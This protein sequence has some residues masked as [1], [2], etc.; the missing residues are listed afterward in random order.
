MT[1]GYQGEKPAPFIAMSVRQLVQVAIVGLLVGLVVYGLTY[2]L[3]TYVY[4]TILCRGSTAPCTA[5]TQYGEVTA[6][7]LAAGAALFAL[8]RLQVFRPLL[9]VIAT[10]ISLWDV[11]KIMPDF[12]WYVGAIACALLFAVS[13][14]A[15]VWIARIRIFWLAGVIMAALV[16]AIRLIL[17]S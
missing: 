16:V 3:N 8:V 1:E 2:V 15:F 10:T 14:M 4:T 9:A 5:G 13:Y 17:L 11:L 6:T 7:I 12:A